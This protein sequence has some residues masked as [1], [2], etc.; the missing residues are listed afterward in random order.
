MATVGQLGA[1]AMRRVTVH[2][3]NSPTRTTGDDSI[4]D[5]LLQF[6]LGQVWYL[7]H[8]LSSLFSPSQ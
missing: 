6:V 3:A 8:T 5:G 7:L 2:Y 4:D 1:S